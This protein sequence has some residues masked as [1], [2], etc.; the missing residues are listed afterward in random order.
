[1][2]EMPTEA[3]VHRSF[4]GTS[5]SVAPEGARPL[6]WLRQH[7]AET[8]LG[9]KANAGLNQQKAAGIVALRL[10]GFEN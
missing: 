10:A 1:M 7:L 8:A 4:S 9:A 6:S 5:I 3:R 2:C